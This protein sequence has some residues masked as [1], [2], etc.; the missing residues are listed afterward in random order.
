MKRGFTLIEMIMV[1]VLVGIL[2]SVFGFYI[3]Q[4]IDIW[5]IVGGQ[6]V[7]SSS[8]RS[9]I[10]RLSRELKRIKDPT[11]LTTLTSTEIE[12]TD[13]ADNTINFSQDGTD[14][15]RGTDILCQKLQ[16][17]GGLAFTYLDQDGA[18]TQTASLVRLIKVR[19]T[20]VNQDNKFVIESAARLRNISE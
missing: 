3:R 5:Q 13:I 11:N 12:F 18:E 9:S 6:K 4:G 1:T 17:P 15:K 10:Y 14:L 7:L 16:N 20:L 19:L 8:G 2:F